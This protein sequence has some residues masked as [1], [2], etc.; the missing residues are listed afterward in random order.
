MMMS[1]SEKRPEDAVRVVDAHAHLFT[2]RF[3]ESFVTAAADV[4]PP[5]DPYRGLAERLG[6]E[7]P[8][9]NINDLAA[10]WINELDTNTIP[11]MALIG[12]LPGEEE[13]VLAAVGAFP[14]RLIG[15]AM[16]DPTAEGAAERVR[17]ML[18][19]KRMR[20]VCLFPAMQR[21][22][23][24][25]PRLD[26]IYEEA[27]TTG[28]IVFVHCGLL[29]VSIRDLLGLP[30][31]F[32]LRRG[33]PLDLM[34]VSARHRRTRFVIPHFGAGFF[35]EA[36]M[37][38]AVSPNVY[39]DTSSSNAWMKTQ[40]AALTLTDVFARALGVF[41]AR[42]LLFGTDSAWFPRGWRRDVL[43][44]QL[45]ALRELNVPA[46]DVARILAGNAEELWS[47]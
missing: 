33:Q 4:L 13:N 45:A 14:D 16:V 12:S 27:A 1:L 11:R 5:D 41:G 18:S 3:F 21:Y 7:L 44:A 8:G 31:P 46:P 6:W 19:N 2:R 37:L 23:L 10:R 28:A 34:P 39:L 20:G 24:D 47:G 32:D 17:K 40:P 29:R 35:R 43:D 15:Y 9:P 25:D 22:A 36:L 30:S 26:P 38:G 42:R